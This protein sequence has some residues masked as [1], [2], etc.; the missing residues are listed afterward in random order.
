MKELLKRFLP[1]LILDGLR[2]LRGDATGCIEL[3][4]W[5]DSGDDYNNS[6]IA[7]LVAA[8]TAYRISH[9]PEELTLSELQSI[10]AVAAAA[11]GTEERPLRVID[12]GGGCGIHFFQT[13]N[14]LPELALD[15]RIV[16]LPGMAEL[17]PPHP[18]LSYYTDIASAL[19]D[20]PPA[21][22][23]TSCALGFIRES[24]WLWEKIFNSRAEYILLSR[25][26]VTTAEKDIFA[27]HRHWLSSNGPGA[28]LPPGFKDRRISYPVKIFSESALEKRMKAAYKIIWKSDDR[29]AELLLSGRAI[30]GRSWF[31][32]RR[33]Q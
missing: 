31:L 26:A 9:T 23:H 1:P 18:M 6:D 5:P 3:S 12:I 11:A 10:A 14:A 25:L 7:Q 27:L 24:D 32:R 28:F 21:L 19:A 33:E 30:A 15:W 29:T 13:I 2:K 8:K 20:S 22:L 16:E 4:G 17:A